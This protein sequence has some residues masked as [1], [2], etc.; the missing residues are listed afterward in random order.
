MLFQPPTISFDA[1]L[2]D[3]A[4]SQDPR[5][6]TAAANALG[7]T[8]DGQDQPRAAR[9]LSAA[10]E[11][12]RYEVRAAAALALG[13][14]GLLGEGVVPALLA[15]LDDINAQVRQSVVI[16][17]GRLGAPEGF[18]PLAEALED[19]PADVRFQAATSLVEI[20]ATRAYDH[21]VAAI[22]TD[23]DPEVRGNIAAALGWIGDR[24]AAGWIAELLE[25]PREDTRLEAA[26]ALARL[27]DGRAIAPLVKMLESSSDD[28]V[29]AA[30]E[31]LEHI[32]D[33]RAAEG[34]ARRM[35]RL[36][37]PRLLKVRAAAALVSVAPDHAAAGTARRILEKAEQ[38]SRE[39]LRGIAEEH[40]QRHADPSPR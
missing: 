18:E 13:D 4:E 23:G 15:K 17:L 8:P 37:T 27:G 1:A 6:R 35:G 33:R 29:Y 2:R 40:R 38:G 5:V 12:A 16:A 36:F 32:G 25:D 28:K 30:I 19:G 7:D 11:D 14:L 26:F 3:L 24:R 20:D 10:L 31:G 9:A 22:R 34:L 21:L 39:D